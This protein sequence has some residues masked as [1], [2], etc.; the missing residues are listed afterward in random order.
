MVVKVA[1]SWDTQRGSCDGWSRSCPAQ[2]VPRV[3]G[4]RV[5]ISVPREIR[6]YIRYRIKMEVAI[7]KEESC[8]RGRCSRYT[9]SKIYA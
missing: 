1:Q 7:E 8:S 4:K 9:G 3:L 6:M 5:R 2:R